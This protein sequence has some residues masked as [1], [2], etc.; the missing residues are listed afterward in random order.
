MR[1]TLLILILLILATPAQAAPDTGPARVTVADC[2]ESVMLWQDAPVTGLQDGEAWV[3]FLA[4]PLDV[5]FEVRYGYVETLRNGTAVYRASVWLGPV[6]HGRTIETT[7][8]SIY[9]GN[10]H[11]VGW[12]AEGDKFTIVCQRAYMPLVVR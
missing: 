5:P 9:N 8:G 12:M 10:G 1:I 2:R 11:L 3:S 6:L 7:G 4:S